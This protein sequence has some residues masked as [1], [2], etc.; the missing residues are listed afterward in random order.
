MSKFVNKIFNYLKSIEEFLDSSP[1]CLDI[2]KSVQ[3]DR[4]SCGIHSAFMI[5]NYLNKVK[6]LRE[7]NYNTELLKKDGI[8]TEPLL[9]IIRSFSCS[10]KVNSNAFLSDIAKAVNDKKPI[11]ISVDD[12]EHWVVVYGYSK[13]C[14]YVLDPSPLSAIKC[15][16]NVKT[17]LKRWDENWIAVVSDN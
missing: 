17:F 14:V 16:W 4:F 1:I 5:L 15:R 2:K 8:D 12:G 7:I 11:L 10:F 3:L 9:N 13:N 6:Y